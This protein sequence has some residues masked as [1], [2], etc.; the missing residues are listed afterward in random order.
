MK[1]KKRLPVGFYERPNGS[2][3]YQF[4]VEK[5]RY[6]VYGATIKECREKEL[7]KREEISEKLYK[8]SKGLTVAEYLDRWIESRELV[9]KSATIRTYKK[10]LNRI[11]RTEIDEAGTKFG[12]LKLLEL[13]AQN[14]R[15]LQK[16]LRAD[17]KALNKEGKEVIQKGLTTRTTNDSISLLKKA[18]EAA[19][20][21]RIITWNPCDPVERLKRSEAPARD[22]IHRALSAEE[23][24]EFTEAASESWYRFLYAFLLQ[25]GMRIGE[26]SA[27]TVGDITGDVIS[28]HKTVTRTEEGYEI[29]EQ[30]KTEAGKRTVPIRPAA[31]KALEDQKAVNRITDGKKVVGL[32][33]PIFRMPKGGIIRPDRVNADIKSICENTAAK[34]V[35]VENPGKAEAGATLYKGTKITGTCT[36]GTVFSCSGIKK[37]K[38]GDM[39]LNTDT[40]NYYRCTS[41]GSAAGIEKFTC[42]AFRSTFTSRCVADGMPVKELMEILGHTDVEM[43]LGL[44]AHSNEELKKDKLLAVNI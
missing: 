17:Q 22:T 23:V 16:A 21:E 5:K 2:L 39:Y 35:Y 12:D 43:T 19:K 1:R 20:N 29:A 36:K 11:K 6:T 7:V 30:T 26:A 37:A 25:T 34:W 31:R 42:H 9:I 14:C 18:L 40:M 32:N 10:L 8:K 33:V 44:Y 13:E 24:E 3:M 27:L 15:D 28:I 38:A 4:T 41:G